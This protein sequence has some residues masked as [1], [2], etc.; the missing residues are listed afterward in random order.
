MSVNHG[1]GQDYYVD[2][3]LRRLEQLTRRVRVLEEAQ[4]TGGLGGGL[5]GGIAGG[6]FGNAALVLEDET[7]GRL[8][9]LVCRSAED[10]GLAQLY[11]RPIDEV[12][13]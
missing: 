6:G 3:P 5:G 12:S 7:T 13:S 8:Y 11:L 1:K 2:N 10:T 9:R 4:R